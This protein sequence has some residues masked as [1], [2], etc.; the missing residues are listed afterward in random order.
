MRGRRWQLTKQA[1]QAKTRTAHAQ[2]M[3]ARAQTDD[4]TRV[5]YAVEKPPVSVPWYATLETKRTA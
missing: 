3:V 1:R 5:V 4:W 2:A